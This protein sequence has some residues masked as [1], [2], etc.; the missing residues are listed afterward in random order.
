MKVVSLLCCG[1]LSM[2]CSFLFV[3]PPPS[4]HEQLPYFDC[5]SSDAAPAVDVAN[6]VADGVLAVAA[7][8]DNP[9]TGDQESRPGLAA[10]FGIVGAVYVASAMRTPP[11]SS[12]RLP[13][14]LRRPR[15]PQLHRR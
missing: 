12:L 14:S 8:V 2:G 7:S 9:N 5:V 6:A 4:Q 15:S 13:P 1:W 10:G 3:R 11:A